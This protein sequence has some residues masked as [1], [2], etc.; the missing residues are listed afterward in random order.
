M[1][2]KGLILR[3]NWLNKFTDKQANRFLIRPYLKLRNIPI[4]AI[5]GTNGKTTVTRLLNRIYL[6]AGYRVGM[7]CTD[8]VYNNDVLMAKGDYAYGIGIWHA[9]RG[10]KIDVMVA[11]TA[12]GGILKYGL[13]FHT[14]R[15][16]I[17]TN[18][19]E[20]HL[21]LDGVHN[22][23]QMA[24]VKSKVPC[25]T[26]QYGTV[27]LNADNDLARNMIDKTQAHVIYFT[28]EGRQEDFDHCYYLYDGYI[29]RK[30]GQLAEELFAVDKMPISIQGMLTYNI[31]NAMA[32]L[33][34]V[35]GM[36][37]WVPVKLET[38]YS[39]LKE[40][41]KNANDN[42]TRLTLLKFKGKTVLLCRCKNPDSFYR[43][44]EVIQKIQN[45]HEFDH[46]IGILTGIGDRRQDYF[47]KISR[48]VETVCQYFFIRPPAE[49][50]LRLRTGDEIV[51]LLSV[52]IPEDR[53]LSTQNMPLESVFDITE[54][55]LGG[56]CLYVIFMALQEADLNLQK[57]ITE[58]QSI[59]IVISD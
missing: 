56:K 44:V 6:L 8:G 12:R 58:G 16:G 43:D 15:V 21:G 7:C 55:T 49:K 26:D 46:T 17:V 14:C 29:F 41:G 10:Q 57:L 54:K 40:F 53:I 2:L 19:Y 30:S 13:G 52:S 36:Q 38:V 9:T 51:R 34:A 28:V 48:I 39:A 25:N 50:Y 24:E 42:P 59:P 4:I 18:V 23:E 31:A 33:A 1:N 45:K 5:T 32:A 47:E 22:V 11:E 20:D 35:E 37:P 3:K 27:V